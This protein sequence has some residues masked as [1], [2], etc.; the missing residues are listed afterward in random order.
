M[1][2]HKSLQINFS[3]YISPNTLDKETL[4]LSWSRSYGF[5]NQKYD[6]LDYCF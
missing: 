3:S 6:R 5:K 2:I 4:K 1:E